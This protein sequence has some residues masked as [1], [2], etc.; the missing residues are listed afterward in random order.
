MLST[1]L[2]GT[3]YHFQVVSRDGLGQ[4][5]AGAGSTFT[6]HLSGG[7]LFNNWYGS[8]QRFGLTGTPQPWANIFGNVFDPTGITSL[9]YSLNGGS[10]RSLNMGPDLRRLAEPGDFNADIS[11]NDLLV[12]RASAH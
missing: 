5:A 6:T 1:L 8:N 3:T 12:G 9:S 2:E 4:A 11:V 10:A 7:P